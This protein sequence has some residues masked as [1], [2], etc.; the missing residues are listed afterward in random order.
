MDTRPQVVLAI[1]SGALAAPLALCAQQPPAKVFRIGF[2]VSESAYDS[3][4]RAAT[5]RA[6]LCEFGYVEGKNLVIEYRWAEGNLE[7][8]Q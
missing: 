5:L 4:N 3:S 7:L 8:P 2:L 1:G 6:G